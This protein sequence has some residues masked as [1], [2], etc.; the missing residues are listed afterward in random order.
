MERPSRERER[1]GPRVLLRA[2]AR[3]GG[4]SSEK[5]TTIAVTLSVACLAR[6]VST[7]ADNNPLT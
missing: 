7:C 1:E 5:Q 2:G 3:C 4:G 6:H